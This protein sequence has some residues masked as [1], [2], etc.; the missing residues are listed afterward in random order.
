MA[1]KWYQNVDGVDGAVFKDSRRTASKF[2]G[3]GKWNNFIEPLLPPER[4][5][6][7]EIGCNAG[8][9]LKLATDAGFTN[10]TGI[11]ADRDRFDQA[12]QYKHHNVYSNKLIHQKVDDDIDLDLCK[13][14]S[15]A[16]ENALQVV[17]IDHDRN[18]FA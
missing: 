6:F 17:L 10:V 9:F 8:L 11:D 5:T 1:I 18:L 2:W 13:K 7:V 4:R 12:H 16:L 15:H 3:S 14:V